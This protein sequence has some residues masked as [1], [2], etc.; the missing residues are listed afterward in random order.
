MQRPLKTSA[1][2]GERRYTEHT[3]AADICLVMEPWYP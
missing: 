3:Y 2:L 1:P